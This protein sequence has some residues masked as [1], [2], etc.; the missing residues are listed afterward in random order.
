[1]F[2]LLS[3]KYGF[4][5]G[6]ENERGLFRAA[7]SLNL[8]FERAA[9]SNSPTETRKNNSLFPKLCV[10]AQNDRQHSVHC[11]SVS[12][13][14]EIYGGSHLYPQNSAV[15]FMFERIM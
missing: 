4:R 13:I 9:S 15:F 12:G 8:D 7:D 10:S 3:E 14:A 6:L 11:D 1:M 2:C 5:P